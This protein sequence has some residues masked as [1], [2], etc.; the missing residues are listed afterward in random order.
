MLHTPL[1]A[2]VWVAASAFSIGNA[3]LVGMT[4]KKQRRMEHRHPKNGDTGGNHGRVLLPQRLILLSYS[5]HINSCQSLVAL[6]HSKS[7]NPKKMLRFA[8][9]LSPWLALLT[10]MSSNS[11]HLEPH[12]QAIWH[13]VPWAWHVFQLCNA[14]TTKCDKHIKAYETALW[15]RRNQTHCRHPDVPQKWSHESC[16][17]PW[18]WGDF[19]FSL[20]CF[21]A[22][23]LNCCI[24]Q[25]GNT[26][27]FS[28]VSLAPILWECL[29]FVVNVMQLLT[30]GTRCH[31]VLQHA[32]L[33][34]ALNKRWYKYG[35][36]GK[37]LAI[38]PKKPTRSNALFHVE[39]L[40]Y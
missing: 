25:A 38:Y 11:Q 27:F 6:H 28:G 34:S 30:G 32:L 24:R 22:K 5:Y 36:P 17:H 9:P 3:W 31:L 26:R 37:V 40:I 21:L 4:R 20:Q 33:A 16:S 23:G 2:S 39:S 8:Q 13:A 1:V 19:T 29:P 10:L 18:F 35:L 14:L 12:C 7:N 15:S